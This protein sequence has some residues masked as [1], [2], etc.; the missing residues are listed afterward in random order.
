MMF[1]VFQQSLCDAQV[2]QN[3]E[4][5][6]QELSWKKQWIDMFF[7]A[8]RNYQES[9]L[10]NCPD[11]DRDIGFDIERKVRAINEFPYSKTIIELIRYLAEHGIEYDSLTMDN[12]HRWQYEEEFNFAPV[13]LYVYTHDKVRLLIGYF[14]PDYNPTF[15]EYS[16]VHFLYE[17]VQHLH[18]GCGYGFSTI[19]HFDKDLAKWQIRKI[20]INP[21]E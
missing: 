8:Y 18:N 6:A 7:H 2:L 13:C 14:D 12:S 20:I 3:S 17:K 11:S 15:E 16:D 9:D 1:F 5:V 21:D 4:L 10:Q 19:T